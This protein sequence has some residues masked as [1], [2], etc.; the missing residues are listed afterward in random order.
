MSL[1]ELDDINVHLPQDKIQVLNADD[2]AVQL[3]A[4]RIVKGTLS[5]T[6][7][8]TELATWVSPATTPELI[9]AIAGR[10]CA[11]LVY[12][13]AFSSE[14][15]AVPEWA[16]KLYNDAMAML[17]GIVGGTTTLPEVDE[18]VT[19]GSNFGAENFY[20]NDD[21]PGPFFSM[22]RQF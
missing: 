19:T 17:G 6:F 9:K 2:D 3:D 5:D 8:A 18:E 14:V 20:P 13:R 21:A 11:A 12:A 1:C 22:T 16:Q 7:S 10:L 15:E 4:E